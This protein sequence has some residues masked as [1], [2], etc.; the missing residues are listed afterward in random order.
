MTD[1]KGVP[2]LPLGMKIK[3]IHFD[4]VDMSGVK[5]TWIHGATVTV[6][7]SLPDIIK[8]NEINIE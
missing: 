6:F 5:Q 8:D 2:I 1:N 4:S 3:K 7:A